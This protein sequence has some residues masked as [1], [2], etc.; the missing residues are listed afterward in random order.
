MKPL[1][2]YLIPRTSADNLSTSLQIQAQTLG[3]ISRSLTKSLNPR[4]RVSD[5]RSD[6][7]KW[8]VRQD[9]VISH[10]NLWTSLQFL[11][12][13]DLLLCKYLPPKNVLTF[14]LVTSL[15]IFLQRTSFLP[16]DEHSQ[17]FYWNYRRKHHAE[18]G[19][20][21]VYFYIGIH[22]FYQ[23]LGDSFRQI[24]FPRFRISFFEEEFQMLPSRT[25][26]RC[27]W[28]AIPKGLL[29]FLAFFSKYFNSMFFLFSW[30][31]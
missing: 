15:K 2:G 16:M 29:F 22:C 13:L 19:F 12:F 24:F 30:G 18:E 26:P 31:H 23:L 6:I 4:S 28:R 8:G 25:P 3:R 11:K 21:C 20:L 17:I 5:L 27:F 10:G 1:A 14:L 9:V 7:R